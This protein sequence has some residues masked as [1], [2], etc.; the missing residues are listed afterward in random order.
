MRRSSRPGVFRKYQATVAVLAVL[1]AAPAPS[2]AQTSGVPLTPFSGEMVL[3]SGDRPP[4]VMKVAH[5]AAKTRI[6]MNIAGR[7]LVQIVDRPGKRVFVLLPHKKVYLESALT[8]RRDTVAVMV[9]PDAKT[10]KIGEET[11]DGHQT[12]KYE[13]DGSKKD[14][15]GFTGLLWRTVDGNVV[16]RLRGTVTQSGKAPVPFAMEM[17]NFSTKAPAPADFA[18]PKDY[19]RVERGK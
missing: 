2:L 14:G 16:V 11:I 10:R 13:L 1:F 3:R 8:A 5:T 12:Y 18:V 17:K 4:L 15:R 6:E 9:P 19:K 7:R